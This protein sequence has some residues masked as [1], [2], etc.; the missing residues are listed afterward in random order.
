MTMSRDPT[1]IHPSLNLIVV[2]IV[3]QFGQVLILRELIATSL[4]IELLYILGIGFWLLG[5]ACGSWIGELKINRNRTNVDSLWILFSLVLPTSTVLIRGFRIVIGATAG[6]YISPPF[7]LFEMMT[8][9]FP[10]G[11]FSGRIFQISANRLLQSNRSVALAYGLECFG[12]AFG[13]FLSVLILIWSI[14]NFTAIIVTA[15]IALTPIIIQFCGSIFRRNN[16][17]WQH[18]FR[19]YVSILMLIVGLGVIPWS[20]KIDWASTKWN[21]P[22]L[23]GLKDTPYGRVIITSREQ[24]I[25]VYENDALAYE[26]EGHSIEELVHLS[27]LQHPNP[28]SVLLLGSS[29]NG[30]IEEI[31]QHHPIQVVCCELDNTA[32]QL[33]HRKKNLVNLNSNSYP[34]VEFVVDDLRNYLQHTSRFDAIL[35]DMPEPSTIQN[36]RFYTKEFFD[37]VNRHLSPGGIVAFRFQSAEN[38]WTKAL[39]LR[40]G[41]IIAALRSAFKSVVLLPDATSIVVASQ[42]ELSRDA[43]SLIARFEHRRLH[44]HLVIPEYIRYR[45]QTDR[46]GTVE[47]LLTASKTEINRDALSATVFNTQLIWLSK[48]YPNTLLSDRWNFKEIDT[49]SGYCSLIAVLIIGLAIAMRIRK[50]RFRPIVLMILVGFCGMTIETVLLYRYQSTNGV[51][52]RDLGWLMVLFMV[53]MAVGAILFHRFGN[54]SLLHKNVAQN[55]GMKRWISS[56][57]LFTVFLLTVCIT[58][59][60]RWFEFGSS[61]GV[62]CTSLI[63]VGI[64]V[65]G[66][67]GYCNQLLGSNKSGGRIFAA[68]AFGSLLACW[69]SAIFIVPLFGME[70]TAIGLSVVLLISW[71][72]M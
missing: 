16:E 9:L 50:S 48:F 55:H 29:I 14:P 63:I 64:S 30:A 34:S 3:S 45:F 52:Y 53:G 46:I 40:T 10:L 4:G 39:T 33:L 7:L 70:F 32:F 12:A 68:D 22:T 35:I 72:L 66:L 43:E 25:V 62:I 15:F 5:T 69:I 27:L 42:T 67:F 60:D 65:G 21:H 54:V 49:I 31:L 23:I 56:R 6:A 71:V 47:Q 24:Q 11:F 18:S 26:S 28:Q 1:G 36:N 57:N 44:P 38:Y 59:I 2:G 20:G 51:L 37:L 13:A 8:T 58:L 19:E 17:T 41:G 61:F